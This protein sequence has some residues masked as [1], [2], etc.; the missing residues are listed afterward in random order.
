MV[1]GLQIIHGRNGTPAFMVLPYAGWLAGRV[2]IWLLPL[3][4]T[5]PPPIYQGYQQI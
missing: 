5:A 1:P 2:D 4:K 3:L